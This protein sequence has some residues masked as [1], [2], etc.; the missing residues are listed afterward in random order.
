MIL[1]QKKFEQSILGSKIEAQ[2]NYAMQ[3]LKDGNTT[4][5]SR[6]TSIQ[7]PTDVNSPT[8][9]DDLASYE[10]KVNSAVAKYSGSGTSAPKVTSIN[11]VDMIWD[12]TKYVPAP[13]GGAY[14]G[15]TKSVDQIK[16]LRDTVKGAKDLSDAAGPN[17]ITQG[18]GNFFVG[19]TKVKI[20]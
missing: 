18:L 14:N 8:Y 12:G 20:H 1:D 10:Q 17:F 19:N 11:G 6:L 2:Q 3:A 13:T 16:F 15:D 5:F 4:L 7:P 9:Q